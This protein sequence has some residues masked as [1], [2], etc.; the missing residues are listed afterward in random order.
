MGRARAAMR[1]Y[2]LDGHGADQAVSKLDRMIRGSEPPEM[3]TLFHVHFE[4]ESGTGS[5]VRAGH[6]P[7]M[8]KLPS[9]RVEQLAGPGTPPLGI[10]SDVDY[11]AHALELEPGSLL[12]LYTDG[13][14]E[15]RDEDLATSLARLQDALA[16]AP[17]GAEQ[18]LAW[19]RDEFR[20]DEG[21]DDVAMLAMAV[22]NGA[23]SG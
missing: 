17:S 16:S 21:P 2:V 15:R 6:P 4:P 12:L 8:L 18:A 3:L 5:Y 23:A 14:I 10:L 19:L 13:L 7:A 9:G 11:R 20:A 22:S 1:A